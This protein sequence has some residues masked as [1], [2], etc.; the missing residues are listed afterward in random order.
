[1]AE[2]SF[3]SQEPPNPGPAC[4]NFGPMRE[5]RPMPMATSCTFAPTRSQMLAI[6]LMKVIFTARKP[7]AAYLISS[8]DSTFVTTKG[9]SSECSGA[10]IFRLSLIH[11]LSDDAA[12]HN[13]R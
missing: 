6:S 9:I 12:D 2:V 7:F 1:M 8:D 13:A 3:E 4:R 5:S 11:L 10:E